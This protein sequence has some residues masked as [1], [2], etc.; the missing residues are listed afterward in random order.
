MQIVRISRDTAVKSYDFIAV[1]CMTYG[2][3]LLPA[4]L[5]TTSNSSGRP[6]YDIRVHQRIL[7]AHQAYDV[8]LSS[9]KFTGV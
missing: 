4:V 3:F 6:R 8:I 5:H 2:W 7:V 1:M 9:E